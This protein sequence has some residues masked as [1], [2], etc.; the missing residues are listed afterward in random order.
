MSGAA[1]IGNAMLL[2]ANRQSGEETQGLSVG[3]Q[4]SFLFGFLSDVSIYQS[5][6][7]RWRAVARISAEGLHPAGLEP[8]TF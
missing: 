1:E 8:A 7:V 6:T 3:E 5:G 4:Q 2:T